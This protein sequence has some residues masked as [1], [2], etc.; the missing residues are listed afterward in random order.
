MGLRIDSTVGNRVFGALTHC[1]AGD[2][3][4]EPST[5]PVFD[6]RVHDDGS[7]LLRIGHEDP[8]TQGFVL[9]GHTRGDTIPLDLFVIGPDTASGRGQTR[10]LVRPPAP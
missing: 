1:L 3:G 9:A 2:V 4:R 7:V 5:F 6:G 8:P 10:Y